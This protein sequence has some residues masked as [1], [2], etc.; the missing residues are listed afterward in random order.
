MKKIILFGSSGQLGHDIQKFFKSEKDFSVI[1]LSSKDFDFKDDLNLSD[2]LKTLKPFDIIINAMAM[3]NTGLCEGEEVLAD[4]L[5]HQAVKKMA[6]FCEQEKITFFH[7]S[8][9]YI[10]DGTKKTGY[11]EEDKTNPLSV[12]GKS[13]LAGE[14]ALIQSCK[15]H[16]IFRVSS[17]YGSVLNGNNFVNTMLKL[18]QEKDELKIVNDQF[19][20]P[21]H[22]RDIAKA[23]HYFIINNIQDYGIYHCSDRGVCSWHEFTLE[24]MRSIGCD[25]SVIPV[26]HTEFPSKLERP[27]YSELD[28]E[29]L[30]RYIKMP[31][32]QDSLKEYLDI[33]RSEGRLL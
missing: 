21:T 30:S 16:F 31:K 27:A 33:L 3:S 13:K 11:V 19:M 29:K 20:G 7:F 12:Y 4:K 9:D 22:T 28:N 2:F 32:W 8:T 25:I 15:K 14:Q 10:F 18:S 5:N 23:V 6:N 26:S 17:L 24:I 1:A